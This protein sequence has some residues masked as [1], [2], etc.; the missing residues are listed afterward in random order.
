MHEYTVE[1]YMQCSKN[2]TFKKFFKYSAEFKNANIGKFVSA[3]P[4]EIKQ[5]NEICYLSM[6]RSLTTDIKYHIF[7]HHVVQTKK[8]SV[9][10]WE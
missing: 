10:L 5:T 3:V 7:Q 2:Y 9:N 4:L 1:V 8:K 6:Q